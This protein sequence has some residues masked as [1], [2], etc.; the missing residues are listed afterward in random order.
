MTPSTGPFRPRG[1][2]IDIGG[3]ALRLVCAGPE[4]AR[5]LVMMEAGA[6]GLA[7]DFGAVQAALAAQGV[8]SWAY[9][10][11]GL[12]WS[13]HGP[14]PRDSLAIV[15]DLEKLLAAKGETG[16]LVLMGHS[17]AGLHVRLFA[18]R[19]PHMVAGVVLIEAVP[20]ES[21]ASLMQRRFVR[22]F[23][24]LSHAAAL[25]ASAGIYRLLAPIGDRIGLPRDAAAEKRRAFASGRHARTAAE[26]VRHWRRS[27]AAAAE[28]AAYD[29][30]WPVAV[31]LAGK[32]G[33]TLASPRGAPAAAA[34]QGYFTVEPQAGH[35]TILG[36]KW[37]DAVIKAVDFV[38]ARI[39][40]QA[41]AEA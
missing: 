2:M 27:S 14:R 15:T 24:T 16:P 18:A 8:R 34:A 26:E 5:P 13:D 31:V 40:A 21:V 33:E 10:R 3:R 19:N 29:P 20:P 1:E 36:L 12:G 17:M 38:L 9:D 22:A 28:S 4:G 6:F 23:V 39:P 32:R 35:A 25:L 30:A 11:A 7:A 37:N 41:A